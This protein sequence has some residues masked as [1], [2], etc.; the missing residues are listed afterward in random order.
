MALNCNLYERRLLL[1]LTCLNWLNLRNQIYEILHWLGTNLA[2]LSIKYF[3]CYLQWFNFILNQPI[4]LILVIITM[5]M[6]QRLNQQDTATTMGNVVSKSKNK[7]AKTLG[8]QSYGFIQILD[9]FISRKTE[10]QYCGAS[11]KALIDVVSTR[12]GSGSL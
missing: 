11:R 12:V 4:Y 5:E 10:L 8:R 1:H 6:V 9:T 3:I 7:T 2:L